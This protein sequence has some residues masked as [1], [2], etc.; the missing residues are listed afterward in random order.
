MILLAPVAFFLQ[1]GPTIEVNIVGT[2]Q[3]TI[4]NV[5]MMFDGVPQHAIHPVSITPNPEGPMALVFVM[6]GSEIT[7]GNDDVETDPNQQYQGIL[8]NLEAGIDKLDFAT[9]MPPDSEVGIV[10]YS[11]GA[12]VRMPLSPVAQ[13]H[14]SSF[15]TQ[16]DYRGQKG[17]D[18]AAGLEAGIE[19]LARA[20]ERTKVIVVI[21]DGM[22]APSAS[23]QRIAALVH[24]ADAMH[25]GVAEI[26]YRSESGW[27]VVPSA[28]PVNS[29]A[30]IAAEMAAIVELYKHS[31]RATFDITKIPVRDGK[32]H[33]LTLNVGGVDTPPTM[34]SIDK[35]TIPKWWSSPWFKLALGA[36][37]LAPF[38]V[39]G[40]RRI[41]VR[42]TA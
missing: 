8:K 34:L 10:M 21:S 4:D 19:E 22:D 24:R 16:Q 37:C 5:D 7:L 6:N 41:R 38:V 15:G 12:K 27:G 33:A 17:S 9:R 30:G 35:Y 2:K 39:L 40:L 1:H 13:L 20:G 23:K 18:V 42:A 14:G 29:V 26:I 32:P 11:T 36:M 25:I 28:K 3:P 31:Y